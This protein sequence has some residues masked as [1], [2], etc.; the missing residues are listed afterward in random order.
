MTHPDGWFFGYGFDGLNRVSSL[1]ESASASPADGTSLLLTITY[2]PSGG[3]LDLIRPSGAITNIDLDNALR[4][5]SFTQNFAGT[6]NDLTNGFEYNPVSQIT[7]LSQSNPLYTYAELGSRSGSYTPNG[8]N[9]I[10]SIAGQ[11]LGYDT[12]GNLTSDAGTGMTYTYDMEN[13]LVAT[14]GS[15]ASTLTYDVL[16]RLAQLSVGG[17]T[18]QFH[19]DGD[20]LVGEYVGDAMQRRYVHGDQVDEPLVQYNLTTVGPTYRR[21][22][23][24]DHQGSIIAQSDL[25]GNL[26]ARNKYDAYGVPGTANSDRFGYTGQT[27]ISQLG[28]N[29][30]KARM[31]SPKLGRFLQIGECLCLNGRLLSGAEPTGAQESSM[32]QI[33][34]RLEE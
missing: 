8:L 4:L 16:G 5:E 2:R 24:A 29:Y 9:Q 23:H 20:A 31:Y 19:Y 1:S 15:V 13:R 14:G 3:R 27:W 28:L 22:L 21:Y 12:A 33:V 17:T 6:A 7:K 18:T 11:S 30:Y 10:A 26:L 32:R 34:D 25:P